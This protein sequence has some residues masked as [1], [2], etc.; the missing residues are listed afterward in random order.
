[1]TLPYSLSLHPAHPSSP[2][3][4]YTTLFRSLYTARRRHQSLSILERQLSDDADI[5]LKLAE[6][7]QLQSG[8]PDAPIPDSIAAGPAEH[9]DYFDNGEESGDP[10]GRR[11]DHAI[12]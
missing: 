9:A 4:P 10:G 2:L 6:W 8:N 5:F 3:F 7:R 12:E 11:L 1:S